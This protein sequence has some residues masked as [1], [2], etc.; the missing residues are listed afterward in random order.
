MEDVLPVILLGEVDVVQQ[1]GE[2]L[3]K[4]LKERFKIK[5]FIQDMTPFPS[6]CEKY[7]S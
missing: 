1:K 5:Q 6:W 2:M 4:S 3:E 7:Y